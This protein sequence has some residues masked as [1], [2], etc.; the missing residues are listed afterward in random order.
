MTYDISQTEASLALEAIQR[1]RQDV[2]AQLDVPRWYWP[3]MA[4]GWT[5]LGVLADYGP[6]WAS[7]IVTVSFGAAHATIG[8]RVLSGRRG[9]SRVS[10]RG[11]LAS[12][13]IP[14]VII[15]FLATMTVLTVAVALL[16]NADGARHPA[17]LAGGVVAALVLAGGP[18]VMGRV[19]A[20]ADRRITA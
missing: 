19:R 7:V 16:F 14:A 11:E 17:A 6:A 3:S 8:S 2:V 15:G 4:A 18:H 12:R 5:A 20:R 13:W 9:S 1:R 10:I